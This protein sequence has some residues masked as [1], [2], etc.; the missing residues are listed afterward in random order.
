MIL[1]FYRN[2]N[3][4][5]NHLINNFFIHCMLRW[6]VRNSVINENFLEGKA[7]KS[8]SEG[9]RMSFLSSLYEPFLCFLKSSL[10]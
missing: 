10:R 8:N 6:I 1:F 2:K 5:F 3:Y 4:F 7:W 9:E